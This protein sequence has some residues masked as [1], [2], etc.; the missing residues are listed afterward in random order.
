[1]AESGIVL[2][3]EDE[4]AIYQVCRR[5][6]TAEGFEVDNAVNGDVACGMLG[7]KDYKLILI[8]IRTPIMNGKQ[9]YQ[10]IEEKYPELKSRV[11]LTTGDITSGDTQSFIERS[12]RVFLPKPFTPGDLKDIVKRTL[13]QMEE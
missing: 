13:K 8:D 2:V 5:V 4:P 1:M 9:L 10:Y 12:G 11:I 6:L 7:K 3:V